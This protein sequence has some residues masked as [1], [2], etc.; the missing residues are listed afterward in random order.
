MQKA[1][2][3]IKETA[4]SLAR[5][6][7]YSVLTLDV[8]ANVSAKHIPY[9]VSLDRRGACQAGKPPPMSFH[10]LVWGT[11]FP[12]GNGSQVAVFSGWLEMLGLPA[13]FGFCGSSLPL[14]GLGSR[15]KGAD[16]F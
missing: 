14:K 16:L 13:G 6:P 10:L 3:D 2:K 15:N 7:A 1:G 11:R 9:Y 5:E 12:I 4:R 8:R